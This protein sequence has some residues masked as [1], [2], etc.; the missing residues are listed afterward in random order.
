MK[1]N[2]DVNPDYGMIE[3]NHMKKNFNM[4]TNNGMG[5]DF[6]KIKEIANI[7]DHT[8]LND[9]ISINPTAE[10][11]ASLICLMVA[12]RVKYVIENKLGVDI[13]KASCPYYDIKVKLWESDTSYVEVDC[14]SS[15]IW[16]NL[17]PF[18]HHSKFMKGVKN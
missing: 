3:C 2:I 5:I 17:E 1:R 18:E 13:N 7:F 15:Y 4:H 12:D 14:V 11:L 6:I 9:I 10:N 16:L 8:K